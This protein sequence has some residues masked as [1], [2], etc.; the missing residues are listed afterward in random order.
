MKKIITLGLSTIAVM[1]VVGC[2]SIKNED[3]NK[4]TEN[5]VVEND[6]NKNKDVTTYFGKVSSIVG[7]EI[8]IKL[9]K[10]PQHLGGDG[11]SVEGSEKIEFA[12]PM[13][14]E[15]IRE[16]EKNGGAGMSGAG[17]SSE[18]QGTDG[19]K[20]NPVMEVEKEKMELDY[21]D[22]LKK[23][24]VPAG[25]KI[26]DFRNSTNAKL[27]NIKQGSVIFVTL[28]NSNNSNVVTN[29]EIME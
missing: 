12:Q 16:I 6:S 27:N 1:G 7:N 23:I 20:G 8:E 18:E 9:A 3:Y 5:K 4:E 19:N 14:E 17:I 24:I 13:T 11:E 25:V 29:I 21:T 10:V 26:I 15:M 28:D 22:E 2:S